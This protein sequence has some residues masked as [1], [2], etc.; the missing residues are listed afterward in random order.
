MFFAYVIAPLVDLL[1]HP[2]SLWRSRHLSRGAAI[3]I[4]YV[5]LAG[6]LTYGAQSSG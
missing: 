3:A 1:Q 5:L 4:L 6:G 2:I